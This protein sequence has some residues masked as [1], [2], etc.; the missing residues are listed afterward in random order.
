MWLVI[1]SGMLILL[2]AAMGKQKKELCKGYEIVI[3]GERT[4]DFFLDEQGIIKLLKAAAKGNIKGQSK[5]TFN[6]QQMEELLEDNVWIKDAQLYFDNKAI[7]HISVE[8]REPVA[9]VFTAGGRSF[10]IDNNERKMP[11]S[12][13]GIAKVPVFTGYPDKKMRA[14][15]DSALLHHINAIAGYVSNDSFWVSQV[16]QIDIVQDCGAGCWQFEMIPVV[17]R[18][19][20]KLGDGENT[21]QKFRRLF[22]FYQQVL[23]R[24]GLD[25]YKII[26]VRFAGQVIGGKSENPKVDSILFSKKANELIRHAK[27]VYEEELKEE[28]LDEKAIQENKEKDNNKPVIADKP[29]ERK[30]P[31][32]IMPKRNV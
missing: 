9:R 6:L 16:A 29:A 23:G 8:E 4:T 22:A 21:E 32:A 14:N 30:V 3:K 15:E 2:I 17:G 24:A 18:H 28:S 20:V 10:Y 12:E 5:A 7:L 1:C 11:L 27:Q 25:H 26:D 13:K 31:R 19:L